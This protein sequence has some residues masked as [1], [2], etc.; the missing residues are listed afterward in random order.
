MSYAQRVMDESAYQIVLYAMYDST[1]YHPDTLQ[2]WIGRLGSR[3]AD[4]WLANEHLRQADA[5]S[6]LNLLA[7]LSAKFQLLPDQ[8]TDIA[9]MQTMTGLLA[10][11]SPYELSEATKTMLNSFHNAGGSAENWA[12][13]IATQYGAHFPLEY[14][15]ETLAERSND[16]QT[17]KL[18][19]IENVTVSPNPA[20]AI[21]EFKIAVPG[22]IEHQSLSIYDTHGRKVHFQ[23]QLPASGSYFWS[24]DALSSGIYFY[25]VLSAGANISSGTIMVVK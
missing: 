25:Q 15:T 17:T 19:R 8:Q 20:N 5:N 11:E 6:S 12:K 7:S 24:T 22:L 9:N 23:S 16:E 3:E 4:I 10:S 18:V 1:D 14:I 13:A 21:V 2:K